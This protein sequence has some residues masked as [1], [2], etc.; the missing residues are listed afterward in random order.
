MSRIQRDVPTALAGKTRACLPS[1]TPASDFS[2]LLVPGAVA[3]DAVACTHPRAGS[4]ANHA[5]V[6]EHSNSSKQA[7]QLL[8][9]PLGQPGSLPQPVAPGFMSTPVFLAASRQAG[10]DD[11]TAVPRHPWLPPELPNFGASTGASDQAALPLPP[12]PSP[13]PDTPPAGP[14]ARA[15]TTLQGS[16]TSGFAPAI[17]H[18]SLESALAVPVLNTAGAMSPA[19]EG[20]QA[21]PAIEYTATINPR[22]QGRTE[23][24]GARPAASEN[25]PPPVRSWN[26]NGERLFDLTAW[27]GGLLSYTTSDHALDVWA[28]LPGAPSRGPRTG[29]EQGH[30]FV[31]GMAVSPAVTHIEVQH[32]EPRALTSEI[33]PRRAIDVETR[34]S[35]R[36]APSLPEVADLAPPRQVL[37][38]VREDSTVLYV[39]DYFAQPAGLELVVEQVRKLLVTKNRAGLRVVINGHWQSTEQIRKGSDGN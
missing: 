39:R 13:M 20:A 28:E 19:P 17:D 12:T 11:D 34:S 21:A 23:G 36:D 15:E 31:A 30:P 3:T 38:V 14:A 6:P 4:E 26:G 18:R 32:R 24:D 7:L 25:L 5:P 29:R 1:G 2:M 33:T 35:T 8:L 27:A 37:L 16:G 9:E 22:T 10:L